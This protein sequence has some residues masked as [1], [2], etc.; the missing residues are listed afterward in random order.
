MVKPSSKVPEP[1]AVSVPARGYAG[2]PVPRLPTGVPNESVLVAGS[3]NCKLKPG[4][5]YTLKGTAT[6]TVPEVQ[7]SRP[8]KDEHGRLPVRVTLELKPVTFT[9]PDRE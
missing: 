3:Q 6:V 5:A 1:V 2:F 4:E 7:G 8:G 9:G